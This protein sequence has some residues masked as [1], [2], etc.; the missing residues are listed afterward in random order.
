MPAGVVFGGFGTV[1][2]AT[3]PVVTAEQNARLSIW[4]PPPTLK[5]MGLSFW[6]VPRKQ[7]CP[8]DSLFW[9][10]SVMFD[11]ET[12]VQFW[13]WA[14]TGTNAIAMI[15]CSVFLMVFL[16]TV[17]LSIFTLLTSSRAPLG[18]RVFISARAG[19]RDLALLRQIVSLYASTQG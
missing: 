1:S 5:L 17:L 3:E 19:G 14:H 13:A 7:S 15:R 11:A 16:E 10:R 4:P 8:A 6:S 18:A 2:A 9:F 12:V